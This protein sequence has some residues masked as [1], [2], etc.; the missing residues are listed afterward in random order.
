MAE[1]W[2]LLPIVTEGNTRYP[3]YT[4]SDGVDGFS[5]NV[6]DASDDSQIG[7]TQTGIADGGTASEWNKL[8]KQ[9]GV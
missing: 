8:F 4:R 6:Y 1:R 2:F 5:G 7:S 9:G 3:K